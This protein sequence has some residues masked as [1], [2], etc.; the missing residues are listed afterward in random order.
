MC[1]FANGTQGVKTPC[2]LLDC[3]ASF[4]LARNDGSEVIH[5][6]KFVNF[7]NNN[8]AFPTGRLW[9]AHCVNNSEGRKGFPEQDAKL[10]STQGVKT[11]LLL[12]IWNSILYGLLRFTHNDGRGKLCN[13]RKKS[14]ITSGSEV[15][16][17][18][19][20]VNFINNKAVF[21]K[22]AKKYNNNVASAHCVHLQMG[23]KGLKPLVICWIATPH[24]IRLAMTI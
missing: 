17:I 16:H 10:Q 7:L 13:D 23:R 19:K 6:Q 5:I 1:A 4:H 11:D 9:R 12:R 2:Y 24:F 3:H 15:I 14:V 8:V 18:Q 20:F 21:P 22:N